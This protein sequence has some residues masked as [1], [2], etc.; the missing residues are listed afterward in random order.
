MD[1][2]PGNVNSDQQSTNLIFSDLTIAPGD[3]LPFESLNSQLDRIAERP[4][5]FSELP[6]ICQDFVTGGFIGGVAGPRMKF[7]NA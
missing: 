3:S 6:Q 1:R 7:G 2:S 5:V 4:R